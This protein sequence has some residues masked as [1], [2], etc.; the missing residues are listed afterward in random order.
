M[1]VSRMILEA[2]GVG[3]L[4][5]WSYQWLWATLGDCWKS[6]SGPS[7]PTL[8]VKSFCN[9]LNSVFLTV[10]GPPQ[11]ILIHLLFQ[12]L[13]VWRFSLISS[14]LVP[15]LLYFLLHLRVCFPEDP[16]CALDTTIYITYHIYS[17][18][19]CFWQNPKSHHINYRLTALCYNNP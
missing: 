17:I 10:W 9:T 15:F 2:R 1:H 14:V 3:P 13:Q 11:P 6:N 4:W 16:K 18:A 8:K 12:F 19:C 5:S 7:S